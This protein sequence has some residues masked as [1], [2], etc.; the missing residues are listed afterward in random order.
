MSTYLV[1]Q[2]PEQPPL[3]LHILA[4]QF[5]AQDVRHLELDCVSLT[6]VRQALPRTYTSYGPR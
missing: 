5:W 2:D 1:N 6:Q 3:W 4:G